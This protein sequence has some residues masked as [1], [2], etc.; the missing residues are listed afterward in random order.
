[1]SGDMNTSL[2]NCLIM[3]GLIWTCMK[4]LGIKKYELMND[5]D[6]CVLIVEA[7]HLHRLDGLVAWFRDF[8]FMME[9]EPDVDVL[10]KVEFCQCQPVFD[11]EE[12]VM[13]RKP[14]IALAK[15]LISFKALQTKKDWD[16]LRCAISDCGLSLTRGLPVMEEFYLA[17]ARNAV[18]KGWKEV[19][20]YTTGMQYMAHGM[21]RTLKRVNPETRY[22]FYLAFGYTPEEQVALEE[23]YRGVQPTYCEPQYVSTHCGLTFV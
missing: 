10:E 1:M 12:Y 17:L 3:T 4:D 16:F 5:G 7:R 18:R 15:D 19:V 22:S 6:D 14:R 2:G 11:G 21:D 8:G 13:V 20:N 23:F 9:R